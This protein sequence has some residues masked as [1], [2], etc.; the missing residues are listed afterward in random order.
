MQDIP[1]FTTQYGVATL[2]LKEIPYRGDAYVRIHDSSAIDKLLEECCDFC[3]MAGANA[4]Y[5]TG[6]NLQEKYPLFAEIWEMECNIHRMPKTDAIPLLVEEKTSKLW[7][8]IYNDK[9]KNVPAAAFMSDAKL[10]ELIGEGNAYFVYRGNTMLGI[11]AVSGRKIECIGSAVPG[12]GGDVL[13]ALCKVIEGETV[14]LEVA[15]ENQRAVSLYKKHGFFKTGIKDKW[16]RAY[17]Y[18]IL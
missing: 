5:V 13:C 16:Y 11:G 4:V 12:A 15:A 7:Q 6:S 8:S 3:K 9:M 1:I 2:L 18:D 14:V 10:A 17:P